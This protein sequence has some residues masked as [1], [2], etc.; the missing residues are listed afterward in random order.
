MSVRSHNPAISNRPR[1]PRPER[2][3]NRRIPLLRRAQLA[4][5]RIL[6]DRV[7]TPYRNGNEQFF[8]SRTTIA[9]LSARPGDRLRPSVGGH[10]SSIVF[11]H[12]L[13]N[14]CAPGHD[15]DHTSPVR[16]YGLGVIRGGHGAGDAVRDLAPKRL[17]PPGAHVGI[18]KVERRAPGRSRRRPAE[19][20][21][22]RARRESM[23]FAT[24]EPSYAWMLNSL[25]GPAI[26]P[27][28]RNDLERRFGMSRS[29]ANPAPRPGEFMCGAICWR[30]GT[31]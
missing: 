14:L 8:A 21:A 7:K 16:G 1:R 25:P 27:P 23:G 3:L 2:V 20:F 10:P 31:R 22:R 29:A 13:L 26:W 9:N 24:L 17:R 12:G 5:C 28:G 18:E 19:R 11:S 6:T 30:S 15:E 4:G